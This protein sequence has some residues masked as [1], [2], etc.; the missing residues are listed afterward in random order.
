MLV[1]VHHVGDVVDEARHRELRIVGVAR[2]Q[3]VTA[4]ERVRQPVELRL[5]E[6][7]RAACEHGEQFVEAG[8]R[9]DERNLRA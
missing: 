4:L 6:R 1:G 8:E 2:R 5:V 9:F 7:R 3:Q